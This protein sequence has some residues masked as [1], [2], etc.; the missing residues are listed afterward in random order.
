MGDKEKPATEMAADKVNDVWFSQESVTQTKDVWMACW[1]RD[2]LP[3]SFHLMR[4]LSSDSNNL[5]A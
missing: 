3:S 2:F 1:Y 5:K 4:C